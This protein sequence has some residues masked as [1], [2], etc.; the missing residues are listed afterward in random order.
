MPMLRWVARLTVHAIL[1]GTVLLAPRVA[2]ALDLSLFFGQLAERLIP[3]RITHNT[4]ALLDFVQQD[5]KVTGLEGYLRDKL[6]A[7][8]AGRPSVSLVERSEIKKIMKEQ[9]LNLAD[10]IDPKKSVEVGGLWGAR[11]LIVGTT[12]P[13]RDRVELQVR[14]LDTET[15]RVVSVVEGSIKRTSDIEDLLGKVLRREPPTRPPLTLTATFVAEKVVGGRYELVALTDGSRLRSGDGYQVR[16]STNAP[17]YVYVLTLDSAGKVYSLLPYKQIHHTKISGQKVLPSADKWYWLDQNT[18]LET[19]YVLASYE[20]LK[21][22]PRR[23]KEVERVAQDRMAAAR[24]LAGVIPSAEGDIRWRKT[25]RPTEGVAVIREKGTGGIRPGR[26][27][28]IRSPNGAEARIAGEMLNGY[29]AVL[30]SIT[31]HHE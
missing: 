4:I 17:A 11:G 9:K 14:L 29:A 8:L 28:V 6:Q 25:A 24:R 19:L 7:A 16:V 30:H 21:D 10:V 12:Y 1:A 15:G 26:S 31:F 22:L 27:Q 20:P 2:T 23:M 13:F 3:G 18:G 5:G